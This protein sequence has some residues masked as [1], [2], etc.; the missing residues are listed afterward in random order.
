MKGAIMQ[1]TTF[2]SYHALSQQAFWPGIMRY[3]IIGIGITLIAGYFIVRL[4]DRNLTKYRD[5]LIIIELIVLLTIGIQARDVQANRSALKN[6]QAVT[7]LLTSIAK[8]EHLKPSQVYASDKSVYSGLLIQLKRD[9]KQTY[10]ITVDPNGK[11]YQL[12]HTH[13]VSDHVTYIED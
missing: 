3:I 6:S 9:R 12:N 1:T 13:L 4:R 11:S 10:V 2:Y 7:T 5:L 8:N